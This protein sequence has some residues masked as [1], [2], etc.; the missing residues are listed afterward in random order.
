MGIAGFFRRLRALYETPPLAVRGRPHV[1]VLKS[2]QLPLA[3]GGSL[4]APDTCR[5]ITLEY[6]EEVYSLDPG[7]IRASIGLT[8]E[9]LTA[10][11][12]E[13]F[14]ALA[15]RKPLELIAVL[16]MHGLAL[17]V[18]S[19]F[20]A[21]MTIT[22]FGALLGVDPA[23]FLALDPDEGIAAFR[24]R[25]HDSAASVDGLSDEMRGAVLVET[26]RCGDFTRAA[27]D[28]AGVD[29]PRMQ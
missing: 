21:D 29:A 16:Q 6:V 19:L 3:G 18:W 25:I 20:P 9:E 13:D 23:P 15:R 22:V 7:E 14:Y 28:V 10:L 11:P 4:P 27:R 26:I 12:A 24:E 1:A 2:N 17:S 8:L 5:P